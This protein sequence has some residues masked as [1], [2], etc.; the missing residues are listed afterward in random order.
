MDINATMDG[1]PVRLKTYERANEYRCEVSWMLEWGRGSGVLGRGG[2]A[3]E[4]LADF[5]RRAEDDGHQI[6]LSL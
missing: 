2:S 1:K 3:E 4:S 6:N 5:C